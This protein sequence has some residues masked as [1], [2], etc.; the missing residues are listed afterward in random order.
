[1]KYK[2]ISQYHIAV[3]LRVNNYRIWYF[4]TSTVSSNIFSHWQM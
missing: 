2:P 3:H 1:L 4:Y